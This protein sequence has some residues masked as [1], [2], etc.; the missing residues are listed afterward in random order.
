MNTYSV[1]SFRSLSS[2]FD[3]WLLAL[4]ISTPLSLYAQVAQLSGA[5]NGGPGSGPISNVEI[6]I[7]E[8]GIRAY[9]DSAGHYRI[10]GLPR[11]AYWVLA[12]KVGFDADSMKVVIT[13]ET[14][15]SLSFVLRPQVTVLDTIKSRVSAPYISSQLRGFEERRRSGQG[16]FVAEQDLRK[17]DHTSLPAVLSRVPGLR[18][19]GYRGASYVQSSRNAGGGG[20]AI[21]GPSKSSSRPGCDGS[22]ADP[23]DLNSPRGCW[24]AVYLDGIPIFTGPPGNAPDFARMQ[25]N[26]YAAVEYYSGGARIPVQFGSGKSSDCGV[27]LLWTRER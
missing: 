20:F 10:V 23:C 1:I 6:V 3:W 16:Y 9:S 11:G 8:A 14:N 19:T 2:R 22:R 21:L 24:V 12:R 17:F 25:V 18:V 13:A 15:I 4:S 26:E 7:R 5:I 27:L